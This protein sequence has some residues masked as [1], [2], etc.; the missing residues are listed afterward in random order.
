MLSP[1]QMTD[2][3]KANRLRALDYYFAKNLCGDEHSDEFWVA[4]LLSQAQSQGHV[5]LPLAK[6]ADMP[7]PQICQQQRSGRLPQVHALLDSLLAHPGFSSAGDSTQ[8]TPIVIDGD[9]AQARLYLARYWRYEHQVAKDLLQRA[10]HNY[11]VEL[12]SLGQSLRQVCQ[13]KPSQDLNGEVDWQIVACALAAQRQ[14]AIITGGPG[15][16]KTTTVIRLLAILLMQQELTIKLVAP[17]GKAA[18]RMSESIRN[19]KADLVLDEHLKAL[20]PEQA[21]TIHRLLGTIPNSID[22]RHNAQRPIRAD[23]VILDEAS[24]V[25]LPMMAKLLDALPQGCRLIMLG[26]KDQLSSV[27]AGAVMGDLC[28]GVRYQAGQTLMSY[29]QPSAET[30]TRL[31]G[32]DLQ[33]HVNSQASAMSESL[34]MLQK[35]WR[36]G[37]LIGELAT[38]VNQCDWRLVSNLL[39]SLTIDS[40]VDWF[41]PVNNHRLVQDA[42]A[43][44]QARVRDCQAGI[45]PAAELIKD[46]DSYR[47]LS[48][49]RKGEMGADTLN[50]AIEK[51]LENLSLKD[52]SQSFYV[53]RPVMILSNDYHLGL[54]NG[55]I[56]VC[57]LDEA[58]QPKV[59]FLQ[60]DNTVS[61]YHPSRLPEHTSAFAMTIH[62]SQGS[63]F[64]QVAIALPIAENQSQT[65]SKELLYTGI[66][67]AKKRVSLYATETVLRACVTRATERDSGLEQQLISLAESE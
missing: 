64:A 25:D 36:F 42:L 3:I 1:I 12:E 16:G 10:S 17:T 23:L 19:A 29:R 6:L 47:I 11:P 54:F 32:F 9:G 38:G 14:L 21:S 26:D 53:G 24:M 46:F 41:A 59:G 48:A 4:L 2:A 5:C 31:T 65:L 44:Y 52:A 7:L 62:K 22:F 30:L 40:P 20:I 56:G 51:E 27:E 37:G 50:L 61:F 58:G 66:T 60:P 18:V 45:K 13:I 67:R 8:V 39:Q 34:V 57:L 33:A 35:S 15:T 63:E 55:D 49:V 28:A 43:N